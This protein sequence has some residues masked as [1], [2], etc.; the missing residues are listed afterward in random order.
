MLSEYGVYAILVVYIG[1]MYLIARWGD[2]LDLHRRPKLRTWIYGLSL[3]VYCTSWTF[4]GAVGTAASKGW[5]FLPIYLG[6]LLLFTIG[7]PLVVKI[8]K[9]SKANNITSIADFIASLYGKSRR[10]AVLVTVIAVLAAIPYITLQLEAIIASIEVISIDSNTDQSASISALLV[11]A[12]LAFFS[13]AFGTRKLDVTEHHRG[14]MMAIAFE[15]ALKIV[16]FIAVGLFVFFVVYAGP[17]EVLQAGAKWTAIANGPNLSVNFLS[18]S[19]LALLVFMCLPR[20]FHVTVVENE[21]LDDLGKARYIFIVYLL[22]FTLFVI[23]I[24]MAGNA[25]LPASVDSDQ[26]VL[27]LPLAFDNNW[28]TL[29]V[30]LGG[31][32]AASGMVII[33]TI[34]LST[35]VSN[36]L[37]LPLYLKLKNYHLRRKDGLKHVVLWSRRISI[38]A[39][40]LAAYVFY[41][42]VHNSVPLAAMGNLS[43]LLMV[44]FAPAMLLGMYWRRSNKQ[45]AFAGMLAGVLAWAWMVMMPAP[46]AGVPSMN[47][48]IMTSLAQLTSSQPPLFKLFAVTFLCNMLVH[49]GYALIS[50]WWQQRQ[51]NHHDDRPMDLAGDHMTV[52]DLKQVVRKLVGFRFANTAF[53][54]FA[55]NLEGSMQDTDQVTTPMIQFT[56]K[57][58]AGSIGSSSAR[59]VITAMLKSKGLAVDE[60]IGLLDETK[61]AIKFNRN[62]TEATLDNISQ[63]VSVVDDNLQLVAW[64]KQYIELLNYPEGFIKRGMSIEEVLLFNAERGLLQAEYVRPEIEKRMVHLRQRRR[65][66][67]ERQFDNGKV[68]QIEGHPM[69]NGGYVT[70]YND[71]TQYKKAQQDLIESRQHIQFYT[72]HSP[73][74]LAYLSAD[75]TLHF[76]NKAYEQF[77]G[78]N[79]AEL[80]GK[81]LTDIFDSVELAKRKPYLDAAFSGQT[82]SFE[83]ELADPAGVQHFMLGTYVPDVQ[84]QKVAGVF[85]I[86][87]D[88]STRR[89]AELELEKSR[90]N[91]EQRVA[92]RTEELSHINAELAAATRQAQ[93]ANQSKTKFIADASH[94]LL[95]PFNAARL[96]TAI[97]AEKTDDMT[98]DVA[99]TVNSLDQSLRSAEN[100]LSALLDIA[101]LDAGGVPIN[102]SDFSLQPLMVQLTNQ[103]RTRAGRKGL[104][105]RVRTGGHWVH[106]DEKLLYRVL[107]NLTSNAI[108]YT[109][110]GGVLVASRRSGHSVQLW[111]IDTGVGLDEA[112]QVEIFNEFKRL[113]KTAEMA[114]KGLGLGLSIVDRIINELGLSLTVRS[115]PGKGSAFMILLPGAKE[116][117][118][119]H[120][121]ESVMLDQRNRQ[122]MVQR[123]MCIDNEDSILEGMHQLLSGWGMEVETA[124]SGT[125]AHKLLLDGFRPEI[126]LVDYQLDQE[127]G[128]DLVGTLCETYGLNCPVVI[129]TA[130]H[131]ESL[132]KASHDA[133]YHLLL[134]PIKPIKLRQL[135]NRLLL[136]DRTLKG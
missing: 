18:Q 119:D 42:L 82:Q 61:A 57:L 55:Q 31:M 56:E 30:F 64:N 126:L 90:A 13:T 47:A 95:Q 123:V 5:D 84:N 75:Q 100:M 73:A 122:T 7:W 103:Y 26:F 11:T 78:M 81:K 48:G 9:R 74:M 76:V 129:I 69:P 98:A 34:A 60:I 36:D 54:H 39:I 87:Q 19:M 96:F 70:T 111:V 50:G 134:K 108:R 41:L 35:M 101:K 2:G 52:A 21:S 46:I 43:F 130:N 107:Q 40:S 124:K 63:G 94:D 29:L 99:S 3:A 118:V 17:G 121:D 68:L 131:S 120:N 116:I 114:D 133:G 110:Q 37:V 88:I 113:D 72:D 15:S 59:A 128:T 112:E 27:Q 58:L 79:R 86:M 127:L 104:K 25:F 83:L 92:E 22:V 132:K 117:P 53:T 16:A 65:Y 28:L 32:A 38:F 33:S 102:N 136:N 91:L 62:L 71:V 51:D 109:S 106:T 115:I 6:P 1:L 45:A 105:L 24:A 49:I 8:I 93:Q 85:V 67:S 135:M 4:F 97:L 89:K 125:E 14:L 80:T 66:Q 10:I 44:Q 12:L 23:P 20:Q 77:L